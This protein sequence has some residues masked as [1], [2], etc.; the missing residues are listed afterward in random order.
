MGH[1]TC[2]H[3]AY[4][5]TC[6][7]FGELWARSGGC[8]EICGQAEPDVPGGRLV[9]DHDSRIGWNA[10]RGILCP[11][12]NNLMG[13]V[14]QG[15]KQSQRAMEYERNAWYKTTGRASA[16]TEDQ[17][18]PT[19]AMTAS[20]NFEVF[21]RPRPARAYR[22]RPDRKK[23]LRDRAILAAFAA[24][25]TRNELAEVFGLSYPA[26]CQIVSVAPHLT[27]RDDHD[28]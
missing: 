21:V 27:G 17:S 23:A 3:V 5:M 10:V 1:Q 2:Q 12:C 6:A 16:H 13:F 7:E 25:M 18:G 4:R 9:I 14:D 20:P 11:K 26:I 15:L 8:C 28:R 24:G 19:A 22:R